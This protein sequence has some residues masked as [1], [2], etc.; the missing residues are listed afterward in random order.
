MLMVIV[1]KV[2]V[3]DFDDFIFMYLIGIV[4]MIFVLGVIYW[5]LCQG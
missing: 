5:L 4:V 2:I 1:W 3:L